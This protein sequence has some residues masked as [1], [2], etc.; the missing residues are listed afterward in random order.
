MEP[1]LYWPTSFEHKTCP[2]EG[3]YTQCHSIKGNYFFLSPKL[4]IAS[5]LMVRAGT[6]CPL[7]LLST[8]SF[9]F[10]VWAYI[11]FFFFLSFF[12][13]FFFFFFLKKKKIFLLKTNYNPC[14]SWKKILIFFFFFF[15][16]SHCH[17]FCEFTRMP[18]LFA[19][20]DTVSLEPSTTSD[21]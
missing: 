15:F 19:L 18:C 16:F 8:G 17:N 10:S 1:I 3:W 12:F 20:E 21:S 14:L 7:P 11:V 4:S 13:F 6:L 5:N 2:E 9:D